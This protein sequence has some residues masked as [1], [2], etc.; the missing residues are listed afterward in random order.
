MRLFSM[1]SLA[2]LATLP[3][4]APATAEYATQVQVFFDAE[5]GQTL[6][7]VVRVVDPEP[8]LGLGFRWHPAKGNAAPLDATGRAQGA[9]RVIW[10][11]E[12]LS[13][14]DPR[15]W[16]HSYEGEMLAGRFHGEGR[17]RWRDGREM[18]GTF[19]GGQLQGPGLLRDGAGNIIEAAFVAGV[20][21]GAGIYRARAGWVW[22]GGFVDGVMQG[23]GEMTEAGGRRYSMV[24]Q[25]GQP[26]SAPPQGLAAH[27]LVA[28]LRPAQGGASMADRAEMSI[29]VDER[30]SAQ[31]WG[32]YISRP[33]GD[34]VFIHPASEPMIDI[35]EGNFTNW[36]RGTL[37]E[38]LPE[39][40]ADS[41]AL[42]LVDLEM[43][44]GSRGTLDS[45]SVRVEAS[46]PHLR[47]LI[48]SKSHIGCVPFQPSFA[49]LNH[50]WGMVDNPRLR[51]R[52]AN[53][54]ALDFMEP[55][56]TEASTR[57]VDVALDG[58]DAAT[59]VDLRAALNV[60]GADTSGLAAARFPCPDTRAWDQ[61]ISD[62]IGTGLF[63]ELG[64]YVAQTYYGK[65]LTTTAL[66]ELTYD[67]TDFAG[68][69]TTE[70]RHF[71]VPVSLGI[72]EIQTSMAECGAGGA[73]PTEAP[74]FHDVELAVD[75][76][77]YT[78]DLPLRGNRTIEYLEYGL[79]LYAERSSMHLFQ[80]AAQFS[81][82]S[83]RMTPTTLFY[84]L[85]PRF[86]EF[87]SAL[88]PAQCTLGMDD[89]GMC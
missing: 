15:A 73:W 1:I 57:W 70:T 27:P 75:G 13:A 69:V 49:F 44:S 31:Q 40:W 66:A 9:G 60:L 33:D 62:A 84:F 32:P 58:F 2:C 55:S 12:G 16:H 76:V 5:S 63:G 82:G 54:D 61:C 51:L 35:W 34:R 21:Q 38:S 52:F 11:M 53:P 41:H 50:G 36:V 18:R 25:A 56:Q 8:D 87:T 83:V 20:A 17:L 77:D 37:A 85:H 78:I 65:L 48:A 10:R 72:L 28:G 24:M 80:V 74:Q 71:D 23:A 86:P 47:P 68:D 59:D 64:P 4:T 14:H 67:W 19:Q 22:R 6:R 26:A 30:L 43:D 81:D 39:D 88:V 79:K 89:T 29:A 3:M 46:A 7:Q 42:A 45:L